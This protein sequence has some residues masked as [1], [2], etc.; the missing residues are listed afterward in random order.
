MTPATNVL[1]CPIC[2]S[3]DSIDDWEVVM[4]RPFVA[5]TGCGT[6]VPAPNEDNTKEGARRMWN[7]RNGVYQGENV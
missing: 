7:T 6:S 3:T 4:M 5:C 2:A 1:P